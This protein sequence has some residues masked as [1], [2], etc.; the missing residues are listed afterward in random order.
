MPS[1]MTAAARTAWAGALCALALAVVPAMAETPN[2]GV[3]LTGMWVLT[4]GDTPVVHESDLQLTPYGRARMQA[5]KQEIDEGLTISESHVK[6]LPAGMPQMM[7]APFGIQIMQNSDRILLAAEV[8][9]LPRTIYLNTEHPKPAALDPSWNGHS[10][11]HWEGKT[12]V[13]DTIGLNDRDAFDFNFTP[14][15]KRTASLHIIERMSLAEGGQQLIDEMTLDDPLTFVKPA[16]VTYRYR[17]LPKDS[18]LMEYV[19]EVDVGEINRFDAHKAA[20]PAVPPP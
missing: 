2:T 19:C 10:I 7:S 17:K 16:T 5:R 6:C 11:G 8:S 4:T 15:V 3:D 20:T 1:T 14:P 18:G 9:N 12:L 13:V